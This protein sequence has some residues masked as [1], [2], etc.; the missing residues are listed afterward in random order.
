MKFITVNVDTL[1]FTRISDLA[2]LNEMSKVGYLRQLIARE[3][4]KNGK[5]RL[6]GFTEV[7]KPGEAL[8]EVRAGMTKVDLLISDIARAVGIEKIDTQPAREA[9][10]KIFTDALSGVQSE[11]PLAN[12][13]EK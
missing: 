6:I 13:G 12:K 4:R 11:F 3:Y 5:E 1:T 7:P 9:L 2:T 8:Q 10:R